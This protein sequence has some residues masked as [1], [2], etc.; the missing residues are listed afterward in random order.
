MTALASGFEAILEKKPVITFGKT[1]YD[2]LPDCIVRHVRSL[3]DLP[4]VVSELLEN[5]RY[6]E[7]DV[8]CLVAAVMKNSIPLNL[9]SQVLKKKQ[10]IS[11]KQ[12][13]LDIEKRKF[14]DYLADQLN[15]L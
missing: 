10:R 4:N 5:Y 9:Y 6:S 11:F 12:E 15:A 13:N 7:K 3:Q 14:A 2:A 1:F 8:V